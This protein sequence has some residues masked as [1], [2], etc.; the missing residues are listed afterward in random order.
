MD[1]MNEEWQIN[2][3]GAEA[4][5]QNVLVSRQGG[6]EAKE[7]PKKNPIEMGA[8]HGEADQN[9]KSNY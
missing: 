9:Q 6:D 2:L 8:K 5:W 7:E 4:S 1:I 3:G